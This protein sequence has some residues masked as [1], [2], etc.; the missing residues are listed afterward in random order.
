MEQILRGCE[1][2]PHGLPMKST[3]GLPLSIPQVRTGV[4]D[5]N[6]TNDP[7]TSSRSTTQQS[8]PNHGQTRWIGEGKKITGIEVSQRSKDPADENEQLI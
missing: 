4:N 2:T 1:I 8:R 7:A 5:C 6:S 3:G